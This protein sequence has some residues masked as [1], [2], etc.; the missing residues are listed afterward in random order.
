MTD[1][2]T[3][4]RAFVTIETGDR[5][6]GVAVAFTT[7]IALALVFVGAVLGYLIAWLTL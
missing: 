3:D 2:P 5:T 6:K 7:Q 4:R 1:S